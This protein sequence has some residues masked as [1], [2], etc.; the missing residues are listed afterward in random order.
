MKAKQIFFLLLG[1]LLLA[2]P[3]VRGAEMP[4]L[5][6][7]AFQEFFDLLKSNLTPVAQTNLNEV[8]VRGLLGELKD[9]VEWIGT[10]GS[11]AGA[12]KAGLVGK[13][14]VF[15][16]AFVYFRISS[17]E[18]GLAQEI[19]AARDPL[20]AANKISGLIFDLRFAN[21]LN[22]EAAAETADAFLPT[23]SILLDLGGSK[24]RS[25]AKSKPIQVPVVVLVNQETSG[26]AE[27]LAAII[28]QSHVGMVLGSPTRGRAFV[29]KQFQLSN[30]QAV[31]IATAS[32]KTAD[33]IELGAKSLPPDVLVKLDLESEKRFLDDP[34]AAVDPFSGNP[35]PATA[36]AVPK[37]T[38]TSTNAPALSVVRRRL[39]ESDLVRQRRG[40][41]GAVASPDGTAAAADN[42]RVVHDPVLARALDFLK[43]VS[44]AQVSR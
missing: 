25:T 20:L 35:I 28:R 14:T 4:A 33:G 21:G 26:A 5:S 42:G 27:A 2:G 18:K 38:P 7:P 29:F 36:S 8:A 30:G 39:T 1:G 13:P 17:V 15:D 23:E 3:K 43:G 6:A 40:G 11:E 44:R 16:T 41:T 37:T 34:F 31:R 12:T 24:V 19:A 10:P 9:R 22:Y 32:V